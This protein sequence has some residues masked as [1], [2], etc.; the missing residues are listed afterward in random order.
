MDA[1]SFSKSVTD[2]FYLPARIIIA[3]YSNSGKSELCTNLI[4]IYHHKFDR[5][6]Y[7]GIDSHPLQQDDTINSKL[8]V[9]NDILNPF[10][11]AHAGHILFILD[12]CFLNAVQDKNVVDAFTKGRH[13]SISSIF[14]TQNL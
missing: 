8:T 14:I 11:Y 13:K 1:P 7:C 5:I 9:S 10:D 4:K 12:D 3:G 6:L 2:I